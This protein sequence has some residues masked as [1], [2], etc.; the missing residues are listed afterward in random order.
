YMYYRMQYP[1][2]ST[3][4][5]RP[6][7]Q[8]IHPFTIECR[9]EVRVSIQELCELAVLPMSAGNFLG[10]LS[11]IDPLEIFF[12]AAAVM[13]IWLEVSI[14]STLQAVD[15]RPHNVVIVKQFIAYLHKYYIQVSVLNLDAAHNNWGIPEAFRTTRI[16]WC[17]FYL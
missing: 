11:F 5:I 8:P 14:Q 9:G 17:T 15:I 4:P 6:D 3:A 13:P 12:E 10:D 7:L 2:A 1:Y 16:Q